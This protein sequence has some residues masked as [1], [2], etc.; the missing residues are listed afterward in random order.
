VIVFVLVAGLQLVRVIEGWAVTIDGLN[1]PIW[2]S[3]IA[4]AA[5][6]LLAVMVWRENRARRS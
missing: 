3:I 1:V 6:A 2:A 5:A 4:C